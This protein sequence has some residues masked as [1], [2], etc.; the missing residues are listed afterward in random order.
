MTVGWP[1]A[2]IKMILPAIFTQA[3]QLAT[4]LGVEAAKVDPVSR[5][6]TQ[7]N[8]EFVNSFEKELWLG[9]GS[10]SREI[11]FDAPKPIL[12]PR[13]GVLF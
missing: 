11:Y 2:V 4:K 13:E 9:C 3:L 7:A 8:R 1:A 5:A 12:K 10:Q 6:L